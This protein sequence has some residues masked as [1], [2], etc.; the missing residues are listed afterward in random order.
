MTR[1]LTSW[2]GLLLVS[3]LGAGFVAV[4]VASGGLT[5][6]R[7]PAASLLNPFSPTLQPAPTLSTTS[8][9]TTSPTTPQPISGPLLLQQPFV[10]TAAPG[11]LTM[12]SD[13]T[14][15]DPI[16]VTVDPIRRPPVRDPL[17][18]PTRSPFRP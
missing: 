3:A 4:Q 18:P 2:R 13:G 17:R 1:M 8:L 6:V 7:A 11:P 14:P 16:Q 12:P 5:P 9:I 15:D 10:A